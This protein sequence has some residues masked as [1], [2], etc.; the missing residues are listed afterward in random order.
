MRCATVRSS[1]AVCSSSA[2]RQRAR[3]ARQAYVSSKLQ[4]NSFAGVQQQQQRR[5]ELVLRRSA[6]VTQ[7]EGE[8]VVSEETREIREVTKDDYYQVIEQAGDKLVVA[9]FY[10]TWCGPCKAIMPKLLDLQDE[11]AESVT[12]MKMNCNKYNKELGV[13]LGIKVAPTFF[14][15][16][17]GNK[18]AEM[19][20]AKVDDLIALIN[21]HK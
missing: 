10:T 15:Y 5:L 14:L 7:A 4:R 18:V 20:G 2:P 6:E 16:K 8:N 17:G 9:D 21:K 3:P 12:F 1:A 19:T 11:Y 13:A